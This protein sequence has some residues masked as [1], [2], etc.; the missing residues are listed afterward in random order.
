M[1]CNVI[2]VVVLC[3]LIVAPSVYANSCKTVLC[4]SG[5]LQKKHTGGIQCDGAIRDYY[6]IV[7][8]KYGKYSNSATAKARRTYLDSCPGAEEKT[9]TDI[10]NR[11]GGIRNAP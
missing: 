2:T 3:G 11:F 8:F 1:K 10:S 7:K 9:K 6:S 4:L 5:E